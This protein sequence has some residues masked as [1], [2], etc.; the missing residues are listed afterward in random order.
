MQARG[1]RGER[2]T[3]QIRE[4]AG[5]F[6]ANVQHEFA[7]DDHVPIV[8]DVH[9]ET[10]AAGAGFLQALREINQFPGRDVSNWANDGRRDLAREPQADEMVSVEESEAPGLLQIEDVIDAERPFRARD[11]NGAARRLEASRDTLGC[12][13]AAFDRTVEEAHA[14]EAGNASAERFGSRGAG[15]GDFG[16]SRVGGIDDGE[17]FRVTEEN[18]G[19]SLER[20]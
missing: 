16:K 8:R 20:E 9:I 19:A 17:S 13:P 4:P 6:V 10:T 12:L 3:V 11:L 1:A 2:K 14:V 18:S 7:E 15:R 5:L